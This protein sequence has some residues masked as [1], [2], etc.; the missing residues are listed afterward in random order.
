MRARTKPN[1][2]AGRRPRGLITAETSI[3]RER[4]EEAEAR[5]YACRCCGARQ[6]HDDRCDRC[7]GRIFGF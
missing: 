6:D 1:P 4:P 2:L 3:L 7:G 5:S